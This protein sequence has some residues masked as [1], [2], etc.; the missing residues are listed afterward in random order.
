MHGPINISVT[1]YVLF[2]VLNVKPDGALE[3]VEM[4][5]FGWQTRVTSNK[6]TVHCMSKFYKQRE[7]MGSNH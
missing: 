1:L 4:I 6:C 7:P 5:A 2:D 3:N